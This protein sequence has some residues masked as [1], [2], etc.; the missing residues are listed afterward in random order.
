MT[1][2]CPIRDQI[3]A[4]QREAFRVYAENWSRPIAL[5]SGHLVG[6]FRRY[7]VPGARRHASMRDRHSG[8]QGYRVRL[9]EDAEARENLAMAPNNRLTLRGAEANNLSKIPLPPVI[10]IGLFATTRSLKWT[11]FLT[12][13]H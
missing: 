5:C 6:Y 7:K 4:F 3:D 2:V 11:R 8:R 13:R 9:R 1:V 10:G 12:I